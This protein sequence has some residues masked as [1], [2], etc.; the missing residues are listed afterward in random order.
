MAH[1]LHIS[2]KRPH[3]AHVERKKEK[4]RG[5]RVAQSDVVIDASVA[6]E[7]TLAQQLFRRIS[8]AIIRGDL[9][10]GSKISE[11]VLARQYGVSRGHC[12]RP[13]IASK[14]GVL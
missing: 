4:D 9:A 1:G 13:C 7:R 11:P 5:T 2:H 10:A 12:A 3:G 6:S 8:E 14:S